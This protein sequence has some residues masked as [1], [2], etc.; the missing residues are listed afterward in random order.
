LRRTQH[1]SRRSFLNLG[2]G[3]AAALGLSEALS[4]LSLAA[5][6]PN[7]TVVCLYLIGGNDSNN[8][9]VPLDSPAYDAYARG[10]GPL[11]LA[12]DSLLPVQAGASARYGFHPNLPGLRD[13]YNQNALA[14]VANVGRTDPGHRVTRTAADFQA[15]MQIRYLHDGYAA[16]PWAVSGSTDPQPQ[17]GVLQ[18][19]H[20]V[21]L[22]APDAH[23]VKHRGV[24]QAAAAPR[25]GRLPATQLGQRLGVVLAALKSGAF[26]QQAFLVPV[27]GFS[28]PLD[29]LNQ[30]A[31][32]FSE[33]DAAMVSFYRAV[34]ELGMAEGVTLYTDTEFNRTLA[35]NRLGATENA[36]GGHQLVLGG[37]TLGG[38]IYGKFPSLEIGGVDDA[39]GNG[40]WIPSTSS[41]QYAATLAYWYG[42]T[43]LSDVPEYASA[44][45]APATRLDFLAH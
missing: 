35:P 1:T 11:G 30:Q 12:K 20:G 8:M 6:S 43:D 38:Q 32:L 21:S 10:R 37:S 41:L 26:R 14:V 40:T 22:A 7:R 23:P 39:A 34:S 27:S 33:M 36:W 42:K 25:D 31:R 44:A 5:S 19:D 4:P 13:L 16:I 45:G 29:Q 24:I 18:L 28:A 2:A 17:R 3:A 15:E 9:I